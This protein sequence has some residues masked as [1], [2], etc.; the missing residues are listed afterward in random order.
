VLV[1]EV[2]VLLA[3][4]LLELRELVELVAVVEDQ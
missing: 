2:E 4:A 3:I 1:V